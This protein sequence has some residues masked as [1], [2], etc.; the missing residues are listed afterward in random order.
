MV[1]LADNDLVLKL[2][3]CDLF[4]Y[5]ASM[6][7]S[8]GCPVYLTQAAPY[9]LVKNREKALARCGNQETL[10]RLENF[11]KTTQTLPAINNL[12]LLSSISEVTGIDPGEQL[13][14]AAMSEHEGALLFTGD[15]RSLIALNDCRSEFPDVYSSMQ[16][17]VVTFESI[18]LLA[19]SDL[20]FPVLKQKILAN[21]NPDGLLKLILRSGMSADSLVECLCSYAKPTSYF[22]AFRE[23]LPTELF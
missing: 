3:Q 7:P 19:L 10:S 13:L 6:L 18:L 8:E 12:D 20:G 9:Q 17:R 2:A 21:A 5:L 22:L 15:K 16:S 4:D 14:F 11:L 1:I 23:K